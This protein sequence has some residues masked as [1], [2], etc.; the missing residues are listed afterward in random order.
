MSNQVIQSKGRKLVGVVVSAKMQK[1]IVVR[2]DRVVMHPK[3]K[4]RY[5]VSKTYKVHDEAS[6]AKVGD[7]VTFQECRPLSKDKRWRLI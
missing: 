7:S 3:Y 5:A 6:T 4:K 1:T 2:V